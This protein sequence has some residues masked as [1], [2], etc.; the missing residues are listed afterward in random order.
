MVCVCALDAVCK[1]LIVK[2]HAGP[3]VPVFL[4]RAALSVA[5]RTSI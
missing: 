5:S 2:V 3:T 1:A 4:E